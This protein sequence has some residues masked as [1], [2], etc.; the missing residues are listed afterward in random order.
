VDSA[1]S[2]ARRCRRRTGHHRPRDAEHYAGNPDAKLRVLLALDA[3][4]AERLMRFAEASG[5]PPTAVIADLLCGA[6]R[7]EG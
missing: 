2:A 4:F 7:S 1:G 6:A 3:E 5:K